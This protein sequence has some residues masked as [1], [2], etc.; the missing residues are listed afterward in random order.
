MTITATLSHAWDSAVTVD[1][2]T[3]DGSAL[4]GQDYTSTSGTITFAADVTSQS[5]DVPILNYLESGSVVF[6]A[7]LSNPS[8]PTLGSPYTETVTILQPPTI[9][10][11]ASSY[12]AFED[13]AYVTITA[14]LSNIWDQTVTVDYTTAD[15]TAAAGTDYTDTSGTLTITPGDS[16]ASFNVSLLNYARSGGG[17]VNLNVALSSPS[18]ADLGTAYSD[19]V[20]INEPPT[21]QFNVSSYEVDATDA[22]ITATLSNTWDQTVT[23]DY[24]TADG[25]AAAGTDY[26]DTS[27]TLSF[28]AGVTSQS[29]DVPILGATAIVST[30]TF[31]VSLSS[32]SNAALA[33]PDSD[34]VTINEIPPTFDFDSS[35]YGVNEGD[36]TATITVVLSYAWDQTITVDYATVPGGSAVAGADYTSASGTLTFDPGDT[37]KTFDISIADDSLDEDNETVMI[38]AGASTATL[39]I[40]DN[41][42]TP[43]VSFTA[44]SQSASSTVVAEPNILGRHDFRRASNRA[45]GR[46]K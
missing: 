18:N 4:A 15:G 39:T 23:V 3:S 28:S 19:T 25:T 7:T 26:T 45:G 10:F 17:S 32:P 5:F 31:D 37:S 35:T 42:P 9:Q 36:G 33:T 44:S 8:R 11:G 12:L 29:F 34:T 20:T 16:S 13:A 22:T 2:A 43:T 38:A 46:P 27:G 41:D 6:Y 24:A 14:T 40:T 21:V 1:Y 30:T